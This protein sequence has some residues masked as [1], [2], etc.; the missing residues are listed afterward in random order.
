VRQFWR[1]SVPVAHHGQSSLGTV[2]TVR[3]GQKLRETYQMSQFLLVPVV[4]LMLLAG[5]CAIGAWIGST[6]NRTLMGAVLGV[7]GFFGWII[8]A[9]VPGRSMVPARSN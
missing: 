7:F 6:K 1:S 4:M 3:L 5:S 2:G 8:I 9:L